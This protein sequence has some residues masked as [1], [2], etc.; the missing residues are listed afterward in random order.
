MPIDAATETDIRHPYKAFQPHEA[1]YRPLE[2][3][4]LHV[5]TRTASAVRPC[6]ADPPPKCAV[7]K[8]D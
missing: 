4:S 5:V 7:H 3:P 1:K 8:R 6:L 2:E